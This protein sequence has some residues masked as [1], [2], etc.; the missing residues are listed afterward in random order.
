MRI[1]LK[2]GSQ[3]NNEG[4]ESVSYLYG[5]RLENNKDVALPPAPGQ[6]H[7]DSRSISFYHGK[8]RTKLIQTDDGGSGALT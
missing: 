3:E 2:G 6:P 7:A 1:R 8:D 4:I 5:P